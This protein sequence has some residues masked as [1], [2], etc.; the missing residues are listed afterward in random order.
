[1]DI[2]ILIY[3]G[4]EELDFVG[5]HEVF[6]K[7]NMFLERPS[8]KLNVFLVSKD[9]GP[10]ECANGMRVLPDFSYVECPN[11]DVLV[12]PGGRG[13]RAESKD[14][15]TKEFIRE[16]S[17]NAKYLLSVCTGSLI[18]AE[19]GLLDGKS[20]TTHGKALQ[21]LKAYPKLD[22]REGV[23]F[24]EDGRVISSAGIPTGI[25][26]SLRLLELMEGGE[27]SERVRMQIEYM[28]L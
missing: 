9:A 18:I 16:K 22:V 2:G 3:R 6:S 14:I 23:S 8:D 20:A 15:T 1:M 26:A 13:S 24:V 10:V 25:P 19:T 11:I 27:I 17:E 4:V 5:P 12:V 7:A 28:G 21:E